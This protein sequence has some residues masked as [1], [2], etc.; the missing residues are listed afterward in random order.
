MAIRAGDDV[1][2]FDKCPL[3]GLTADA[4]PIVNTAYTRDTFTPMFRVFQELEGARYQVFTLHI[5]DN[6]HQTEDLGYF[7]IRGRIRLPRGDV[8]SL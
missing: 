1:I 7:K 5:T 3:S 8:I 4:Y 6:T 2:K